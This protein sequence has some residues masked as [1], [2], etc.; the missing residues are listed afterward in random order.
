M[1][2]FSSVSA[3]VQLSIEGVLVSICSC[4]A[5]YMK[6]FC[7]VSAAVQLSIE[8]V[9]FS[10]SPSLFS[11]RELLKN[12]PFPEMIVRVILIHKEMKEWSKGFY[13][14]SVGINSYIFEENSQLWSVYVSN[15]VEDGLGTKQDWLTA[16]INNDSGAQVEGICRFVNTTM[17]QDNFII[18]ARTLL[19]KTIMTQKNTN[20]RY[21]LNIWKYY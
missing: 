2:E 6:E 8:G 5:Q 20:R 15:V 12:C 14:G 21:K 16:W 17:K 19:E 3:A 10:H 4:S 18:Y 9:L 1:K 11:S 13:P 7:S